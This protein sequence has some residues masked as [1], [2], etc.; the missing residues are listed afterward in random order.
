MDPYLLFPVWLL[1]AALVLCNGP[2]AELSKEL[3]EG[4]GQVVGV[5]AAGIGE[6]PGVAAAEG[7]LLEA[8]AGVFDAGDD[9]VGADADEGDDGGAPT[10]DFGFQALAA[11][12]KFVVGEFSGAGGGAFYDV[13]DA[14]F[15]VEKEGSF[16]G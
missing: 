10:F 15:E 13:G 7:G 8:D 16:K 5:E 4:G 9:A 14:E 1:S 3:C 2:D 11:G 12:A 6:D